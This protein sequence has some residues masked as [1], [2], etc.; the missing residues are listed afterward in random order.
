M[1]NKRTEKEKQQDRET[2]EKCIYGMNLAKEQTR[3]VQEN[4][5]SNEKFAKHLMTSSKTK[6]R[7]IAGSITVQNMEDFAKVLGRSAEE[8]KRVD[9]NSIL[10]LIAFRFSEDEHRRSMILAGFTIGFMFLSV[11]THNLGPMLLMII[12]ATLFL[13]YGKNMWNIKMDAMHNSDG[14]VSKAMLF[15]DFA[16]AV[17]TVILLVRICMI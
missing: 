10:E 11:F 13:H 17:S 6:N 8:M 1:F 14:S 15:M 9:A 2:M 5:S 4:D 3:W 12:F 7:A 16:A